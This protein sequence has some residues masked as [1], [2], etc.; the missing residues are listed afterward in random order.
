MEALGS[1]SMAFH[2]FEAWGAAEVSNLSEYRKWMSGKF[3]L[4]GGDGVGCFEVCE[5]FMPKM[6]KEFCSVMCVGELKLLLQVVRLHV[7]DDFL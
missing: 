5:N 4:G 3:Q 1:S 2:Q 6:C 7:L